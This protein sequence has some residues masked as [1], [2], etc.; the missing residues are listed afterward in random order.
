MSWSSTA[1]RIGSAVVALSLLA[2]AAVL[3]FGTDVR[4]APGMT[5]YRDPNGPAMR[6]LDTL[7]PSTP[8]EEVAAVERIAA[9]PSATWL[10]NTAHSQRER[11]D[12]LVSDAQRLNALP[13]LV[14]YGI[15]DRDCGLYSSGGANSAVEYL[16]WVR[17]I[18]L[19]IGNRPVWVI[20]EPDAVAHA[21]SGCLPAEK[22]DDR[23]LALQSAV[24]ILAE[25]EQTRVY[26]DSGNATWD[27]ATRKMAG[28]LKRA[29]IRY[30]DGM[31]LNV[32]NHVATR[33]SIN[34]GRRLAEFTGVE[35]M[36]ID[37]SRNG[38]RV[39]GKGEARWCN[40]PSAKLGVNPTTT[41][42]AHD[43]DGLLWI[44]Q[45]GN[46][47]GECGRDEPSAGMWWSELAVT[48]AR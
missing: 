24:R 16:D 14:V 29:G 26:L 23:L 48:L 4:G 30:A 34:Y 33:A 25:G 28:L 5:L 47:D 39:T 35:K 36:V 6:A 20:L 12:A 15:P 43:V 27:I 21:A 9:Q 8:V 7:L 40:N 44:K 22:V 1:V 31:A 46:S 37:V 32:S 10:T 41:T 13:V 38:A 19:G 3:A 11:V 2:L 42:G 18:A 17:Q 45:P